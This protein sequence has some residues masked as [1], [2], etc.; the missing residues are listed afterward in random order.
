MPLV[1]KMHIFITYSWHSDSKG[2]A[3]SLWDR[4]FNQLRGVSTIGQLLRNKIKIQ[5]SVV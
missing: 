1:I 3:Q 4:N 5:N 2:F